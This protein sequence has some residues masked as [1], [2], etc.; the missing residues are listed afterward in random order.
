MGFG[1]TPFRHWVLGPWS[2]SQIDGL[3]ERKDG[4]GN[5]TILQGNQGLRES[6]MTELVPVL[7]FHQVAQRTDALLAD[8]K[9]GRLRPHHLR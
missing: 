6:S 4:M 3:N 5:M 2:P 8:L 9:D 7:E 1:A